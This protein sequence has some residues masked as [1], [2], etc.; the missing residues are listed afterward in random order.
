MVASA[1]FEEQRIREVA[2]SEVDLSDA[3]GPEHW[4]LREVAAERRIEI[5]APLS[6]YQDALPESP[7]AERPSAAIA[8]PLASPDQAHAYGVLICGVSPHRVLDAGYRTF[9][10]LTAAQI[11]SAIRDARALEQERKRA[12]A[13]AAIDRAKTAFF[14]NVSHEFRTPLTLVTG[15]VAEVMADRAVPAPARAWLRSGSTQRTADQQGKIDSLLD[16]SRIEVGRVQASFRP[17]TSPSSRAILQA[18]SAPRWN[19]RG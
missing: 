8:L 17:P 13:L 3:R 9:F 5:L 18:A 2:P 7:W 6:R 15:P 19:R 1:G 14:S 11:V 4:P 12:E 16:F 10:E